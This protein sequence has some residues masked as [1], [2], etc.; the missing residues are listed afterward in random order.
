MHVFPDKVSEKKVQKNTYAKTLLSRDESDSKKVAV[1]HL[2]IEEDGE[3]LVEKKKR[4]E[5]VVYVISGRGLW[6]WDG[7]N[8][9]ATRGRILYTDTAA[10]DAEGGFLL[11]NSG[12]GDLRVLLISTTVKT[13]HYEFA[14][15]RMGHLQTAEE[16]FLAGYIARQ[17]F[18]EEEMVIA[19][20][21]RCHG[22]DVETLA[23]E[24]EASLHRDPEEVL[25]VLRGEGEIESGG[26]RKK[27]K[28][29]TLVY[30]PAGVLHGIWNTSR[31]DNMQYMVIEFIDP[32]NRFQPTLE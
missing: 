29:G 32:K 28:P 10:W 19:G 7:D 22:L 16:S 12:E 24:Y 6:Q 15:T 9:E 21:L 14:R 13:D 17:F 30:T 5:Y 23:P 18:E 8:R 20:S 3:Y 4:M 2:R 27:V 1:E 11:S 26:E 31:T 25:Y